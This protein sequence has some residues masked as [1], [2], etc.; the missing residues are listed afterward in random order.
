MKNNILFCSKTSIKKHFF[1]ESFSDFLVPLLGLA[2]CS[3]TI[4]RRANP[5]F[6]HEVSSEETNETSLDSELTLPESIARNFPL[7]H[8]ETE[9]PDYQSTILATRIL[10]G[11][12]QT[13]ASKFLRRFRWKEAAS[14]KNLAEV[15]RD[16]IKVLPKV[17]KLFSRRF[18]S[19]CLASQ[20]DDF[21]GEEVNIQQS[22]FHGIL[23]V[24][25]SRWIDVRT[26]RK[27]NLFMLLVE[28]VRK[29]VEHS[30]SEHSCIMVSIEFFFFFHEC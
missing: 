8:F 9:H 21:L 18:F 22:R 12:M 17:L 3:I 1:L 7:E 26:I 28:M 30:D 5:R 4:P 15:T 2:R 24:R 25:K 20:G 10:L 14:H 13:L 16:L 23:E 27:C 29:R 11:F 19:K 6:P